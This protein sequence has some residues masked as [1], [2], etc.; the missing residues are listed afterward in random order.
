LRQPIDFDPRLPAPPGARRAALD[1]VVALL[2]RE[3]TLLV[4]RIEVRALS[5]GEAARRRAQE[6]AD[7]LLRWLASRGIDAERL[8][9]W[10]LEASSPRVS[11]EF[12]DG[13]YGVTLEIVQRARKAR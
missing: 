10:G 7:A 3:P 11:A 2:T 9:A 13:A 5:P 4:L 8:D 12:A 6:R 1:R